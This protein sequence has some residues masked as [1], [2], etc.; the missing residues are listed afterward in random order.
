MNID[1][2]DYSKRIK[3]LETYLVLTGNESHLNNY[4]SKF[5]LS[6]KEKFKVNAILMENWLKK[7]SDEIKFIKKELKNLV[8]IM[9]KHSRRNGFDVQYYN[10]KKQ[11]SDCQSK[12]SKIQKEHRLVSVLHCV[13]WNNFIPEINAKKNLNWIH[14]AMYTQDLKIDNID[15]IKNF[16]KQLKS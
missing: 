10:Y 16:I 4:V 6:K 13:Y 3:F 2:M 12:L 15:R 8:L 9:K 1:S 14:L 11:F 7:S 5:S